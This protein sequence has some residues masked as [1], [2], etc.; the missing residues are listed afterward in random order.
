MSAT[1]RY[2]REQIPDAAN[3]YRAIHEMWIENGAIKS[4]KAFKYDEDGVSAEWE[5][6][7]TPQRTRQFHS[8]NPPEKY[9]VCCWNAGSIRETGLMVD[10]DPLPNEKLKSIDNRAHCLLHSTDPRPED[11]KEFQVRLKRAT[12]II[13][14]PG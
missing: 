1:P 2:A 14:Y 9:G 12:K 10:H 6:Y 4:V 11:I 8:N 7:T 3:I 13:L 5:K